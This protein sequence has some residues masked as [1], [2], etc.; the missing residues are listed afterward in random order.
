MGREGKKKFRERSKKKGGNGSDDDDKFD[1]NVIISK[2]SEG[3]VIP[4][5]KTNRDGS[6]DTFIDD[7]YD[8]N[9]F[10]KRNELQESRPKIPDENNIDATGRKKD[11]VTVNKYFDNIENVVIEEKPDKANYDDDNNFMI[12]TCRDL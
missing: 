1:D 4:S 8:L 6:R 11:D 10:W 3:N 2:D 12:Q 9:I 7:S 5:F